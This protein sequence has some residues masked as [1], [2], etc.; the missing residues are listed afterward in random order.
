MKL[1]IV[2]DQEYGYTVYQITEDRERVVSFKTEE[3]ARTYCETRQK[4][5]VIAEYE[6]G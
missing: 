3:E 5:R 1:Q 2:H 6:F 4:A